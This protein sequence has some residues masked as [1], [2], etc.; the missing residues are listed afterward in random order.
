MSGMLASSSIGRA[1]EKLS[2]F[3]RAFSSVPSSSSLEDDQEELRRLERTM[4]RIRATL[5]DADMH[6]NIREE[7]TKLRLKELKEV[8]YDAEDVVEEYE[9][10]VNLC[11]VEALDRSAGRRK[12][13]ETLSAS[14]SSVTPTASTGLEELRTS[15]ERTMCSIRAMLHKAEEA[16]QPSGVANNTSKCKLQEESG[17]YSMDAGVIAVP[18]ELLLQTRKITERFSE[19]INYSDHFTLS[20]DDGEKQYTPSITSSRHTSSIV[21]EKSIQGR[22]Q[23]KVR[24]VKKILSITG[25][26]VGSPVSVMAIVGMGGLGKT[27]LAQLVYNDAMVHQSFHKLAWVYV[28]EHL[29]VNE[30]TKKLYGSLTDEMCDFTELADMQVKLAAEIK[31]KRVL[32][33]LDDVWSER[34]DLWELFCTPLS[35]ARICQ[36]IVT[37]RNEAVAKLIQT[38]PCY[39]LNCLSSYQSWSLFKQAAFI[40]EKESDTPANLIEIGKSIVEKCKG[41]PLAIKVLGSMLRYESDQKIWEDVLQNEM[42]DLEQP[43]N[44]VLPA[45]E[46]SFKHM[47]VCLRRCFLTL[48]LFPKTHSLCYTTITRFWELLDLIP[49]DSSDN[50]YETG[51]MYLKE[52]ILRSMLQFD[53]R[54]RYRMHDLIHD[55]ACFLAEEEFYKLD[56][57]T[58]SNEIPQTI[59]YL[60]IPEG[61]GSFEIPVIPHSL[62]AL[63]YCDALAG[64]TSLKELKV[65]SENMGKKLE[66]GYRKG[67]NWTMMTF[68][69][70]LAKF[71]MTYFEEDGLDLMK[72]RAFDMAGILG[73]T[74]QVMFNGRKM[75][76][77]RGFPCY[78]HRHIKPLSSKSFPWFCEKVNDQL[79]VGVSLSGGQFKQLVCY[80]F[81]VLHVSFVNKFATI[82]GG[83]HVDY[84]SNLIVAHATSFMKDTLQL[85]EIEE[86]DLKRQLMIFIK[87]QMENPTFSSPTKEAL[88]TPREEFASEFQFSD[89]FLKVK[90]D[91]SKLIQNE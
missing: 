41:L 26:S 36:I 21:F 74:V 59:R 51:T 42:W 76:L 62:R 85:A 1:L 9:Y 30:I 64:L 91:L 57:D 23:D 81:C 48:S 45:L 90:Q 52:L 61:V 15:L 43:R 87:V 4:R 20:E 77:L 40:V 79:E 35:T 12:I 39:H 60:Y 31:G 11:R 25:K 83:N 54:I 63:I 50:K 73:V 84:V 5:H 69:P 70:D 3:L 55:L 29:D 65:F 66:P 2:S 27:T 67:V 89:K 71:N 19:I 14:S 16:L 38:M 86:C 58:S 22:D 78:V 44:E 53:H 6:W 17:A 46:L 28:S 10:E 8:A 7:S 68:K 13:Q 34:R 72:K 37:T 56:E 33:V 24:I 88:A 75:F 47:P 80:T 49:W 18:N 32:L 82:S